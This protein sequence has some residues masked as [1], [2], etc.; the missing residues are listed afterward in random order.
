MSNPIQRNQLLLN[1]GETALKSMEIM[2]GILEDEV[3]EDAKSSQRVSL[4][5]F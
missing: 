3:E 2:L 5:F 4:K 1:I